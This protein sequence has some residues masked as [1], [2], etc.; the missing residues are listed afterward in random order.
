MPG[1]LLHG[2]EV[3]NHEV[4]VVQDLG[5]LPF[6]VRALGLA[7]AA[8]ELVMHHGLAVRCVPA[9]HHPLDPTALVA[10]RPDDRVDQ[11][12]DPELARR[13]LLA[14]GVHQERR[15]VRVRLHDRADRPV[16]LVGVRG[17][18]HA[19]RRRLVPALVGEGERRGD[20]RE[21]EVGPMVLKLLIGEPSQERPRE[22]GEGVPPI[23]GGLGLDASE[24]RVEDGVQ[25][26][27]LLGG[28][29]HGVY[30]VPQRWIDS[31]GTLGAHIVAAPRAA[32]TTS[33]ARSY[34]P[35]CGIR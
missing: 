15:V 17:H 30:G 19:D 22:G 35:N 21:Q 34:R 27:R 3:A 26:V 8:F 1:A 20:H 32:S 16:A 12:P 11:Q 33:A 6:Q 24:Q 31:A 2:L 7:E 18:E 9:R 5:D 25:R 10:N 29:G 28:F 4:H 13:E 14:D 23:G